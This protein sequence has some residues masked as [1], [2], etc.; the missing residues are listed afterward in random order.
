ML[1]NHAGVFT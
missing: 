1:G